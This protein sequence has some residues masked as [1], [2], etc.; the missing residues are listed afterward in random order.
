MDADQELMSRAQTRIGHV[1]RGKYRV[2][3][4][5]GVGGMAVVYAATH[6]NKKRFALKILHPELSLR[7]DL[8]QRFLRE[9]YA[10]NSVEHPGAVTI[11][12]DDIAE[13]GA[14]FLVMEL[15]HGASVD[16]LWEEAD[17]RLAVGAVLTIVHDLLDTLAVAHDKA[18]VH[19]DIKPANV[20]VT[21]A[22]VVKVLDF[23]IARVKDATADSQ[24]TTNTGTMLGTPAFMAPEQAGGVSSEIDG[25]TDLWAVGATMFALLSGQYVHGGETPA[26]MAIRTATEPARSLGTI[27]PDT[28]GPV[29]AIVDRALAFAKADRWA[30]AIAMRDAV[31]EAH[32]SLFG[33]MSKD[34]LVALVRSHAERSHRLKATAPTMSAEG[35]DAELAPTLP[36]QSTPVLGG[37]SPLARSTRREPTATTGGH[38]AESRAVSAPGTGGAPRRSRA[39]WIAVP[40]GLVLCGGAAVLALRAPP[41]EVQR[42]RSPAVLPSASLSSSAAGAAA[43]PAAP[44]LVAIAPADA[45]VEVDGKPVAVTDGAVSVAGTAGSMHLLHLSA[46]GRDGTYPVLLTEGG[47]VPPRVDLSVSP[48]PIVSTQPGRRSPRPTST[49]ISTPVPQASARAAGAPASPA[50]STSPVSRTME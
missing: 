20:F 34:P 11:L 13:D 37:L 40:L 5:L 30:D 3:S 22:G 50:A 6:R 19:R 47:P 46:Q 28:P 16:T 32:R 4:V 48:A 2:D 36:Q 45:V 1:L 27:V 44:V 14:A 25:R 9:G 7:S 49:P 41:G 42:D 31:A 12:D 18:I 17:R 35:S 39:A 38:V 26:Q 29:V 21:A 43:P 24:S 15:L 33:P 10:A 23:G 8:R